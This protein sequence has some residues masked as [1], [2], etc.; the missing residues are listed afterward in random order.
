MTGDGTPITGSGAA[1]SS[2]IDRIASKASD[3]LVVFAMPT[4]AAAASG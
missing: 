1:R 4:A 3:R 2:N